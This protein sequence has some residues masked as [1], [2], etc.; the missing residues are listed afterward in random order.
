MDHYID[1]LEHSDDPAVRRRDW[2]LCSADLP[3]RRRSGLARWRDGRSRRPR[4]PRRSLLLL[5]DASSALETLL[6]ASTA[7]AT[8][9]HANGGAYKRSLATHS[10][11][12]FPSPLIPHPIRPSTTHSCSTS[13]RSIPHPENAR[14]HRPCP[15]LRLA[16]PSRTR[17]ANRKLRPSSC[18]PATRT[19]SGR[20][21]PNT[22]Q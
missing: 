6:A 22:C 1:S 2:K 20:T 14:Q 16:S 4:R 9:R 8:K 5:S 7:W 19:I 17:H 12:C 13:L 3:Q 21:R 18:R 15:H 11:S 10:R